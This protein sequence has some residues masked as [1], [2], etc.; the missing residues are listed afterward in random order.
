MSWT[1]LKRLRTLFMLENTRSE[2]STG[3]V[4]QQ[5]L[6]SHPLQQITGWQKFFIDL[7]FL[8]LEQISEVRAKW[9]WSVITSL[10]M[11]LSMIFGL[12]KIGSGLHDT[13]SLLFII[14]GAT[15]FSVVMEG[16]VLTAQRVGMMK[17]LGILT[18]YASLPISKAAFAMAILFARLVITLPG[19]ILTIIM[20]NLL[21]HVHLHIDL[22]V[23][24]VLLLTSLSLSVSG[25]ALGSILES[26]EA[27]NIVANILQFILILA[28]PIFIPVTSLPVPLQALSYFLPPSYAA[29]ALRHALTGNIDFIFLWN[30]A[31]LVGITLL[32]FYAATRWL[33]WRIA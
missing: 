22:W 27:V 16:V 19:M 30:I 28:A 8:W 3:I 15:I 31:V 20:G 2:Q 6:S 24:A 13:S 11:P 18:Y 26:I 1:H 14:S 25:L 12:E 32:G 9:Y 4:E 17:H 33:R 29:T 21:Y 23:I 10:L 5:L 7:K